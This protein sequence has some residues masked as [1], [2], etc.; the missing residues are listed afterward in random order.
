MSELKN[1]LRLFYNKLSDIRHS[2]DTLELQNKQLKKERDILLEAVRF[3]AQWNSELNKSDMR[4]I[5][6]K[7]LKDMGEK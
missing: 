4:I 5:A 1:E 6:I 3:Y 2:V 7:A